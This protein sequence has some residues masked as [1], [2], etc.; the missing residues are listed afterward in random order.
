MS[1]SLWLCV[2]QSEAGLSSS[3]IFTGPPWELL[4][5]FSAFLDFPGSLLPLS[6]TQGT[7]LLV[8]IHLQPNSP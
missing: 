2:S 3:E 5:F 8:L 1:L 7:S 6:R 4:A